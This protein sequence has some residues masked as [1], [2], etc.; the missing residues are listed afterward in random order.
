MARKK[1][2]PLSHV[3]IR[4]PKKMAAMPSRMGIRSI[5]I[6]KNQMSP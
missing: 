3:L 1:P 5:T 6:Q 2:R 4:K